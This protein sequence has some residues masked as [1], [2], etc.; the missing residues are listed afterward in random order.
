[1]LA[2]IKTEEKVFSSL[3]KQLPQ[4]PHAP[5]VTPINE[6]PAKARETPSAKSPLESTKE[7]TSTGKRTLNNELV[8]R[9]FDCQTPVENFYVHAD[10]FRSAMRKVD[11]DNAELE[12]IS[13]RINSIE[14]QLQEIQHPRGEPLRPDDGKQHSVVLIFAFLTFHPD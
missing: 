3:D 9:V 6:S 13:R 5:K 12:S 10:A 14:R 4:S 1:M 11:R 8:P 7:K 2:E